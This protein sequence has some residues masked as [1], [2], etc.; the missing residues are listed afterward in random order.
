MEFRQTPCDHAAQRYNK[1]KAVEELRFDKT[2]FW[3]QVHGLPYRF[4]NIKTI[5]CEW[6]GMEGEEKGVEG[7]V[8]R[9]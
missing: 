3:V 7:K 9:T 8:A 5:Y 2:L 6:R 4:M 1:S